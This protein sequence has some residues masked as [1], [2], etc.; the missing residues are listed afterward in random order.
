MHI[1]M[2]P[3]LF[4]TTLYVLIVTVPLREVL[5]KIW[6]EKKEREREKVPVTQ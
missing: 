4:I 5:N 1:T 2:F 6:K 3:A